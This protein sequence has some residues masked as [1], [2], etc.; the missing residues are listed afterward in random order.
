MKNSHIVSIGVSFKTDSNLE[1]KIDLTQT[2]RK[3]EK[4]GWYI[5][6]LDAY[7]LIA[8][9]QDKNHSLQISCYGELSYD[10]EINKK[11]ISM[12]DLLRLYERGRKYQDS[13]LPDIEYKRDKISF[14]FDT[15]KSRK[16]AKQFYGENKCTF[17]SV[18]EKFFEKNYMIDNP[19]TVGN[20]YTSL[21][22]LSQKPL[23]PK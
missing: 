1:K 12:E 4:Q 22:I 21:T 9:S 23:L 8:F 15:T 3:I 5:F 17:D 2:R 19:I 16:V 6:H 7:N 11:R 10:E 14:D 13:L 20:Y 18:A